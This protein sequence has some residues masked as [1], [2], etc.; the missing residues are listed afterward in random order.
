MDQELWEAI[1]DYSEY[2]QG[3][4]HY[5]YPADVAC[6]AMRQAV[7]TLFEDPDWKAKYGGVEESGKPC[8][9]RRWLWVTARKP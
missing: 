6:P 9:P 5:R 2:A 8:I 3:A 7:R 4:L 1:C